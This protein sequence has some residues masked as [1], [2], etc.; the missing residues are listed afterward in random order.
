MDAFQVSPNKVIDSEQKLRT[1]IPAYSH[2]L[3]K[4]IRPALDHYCFEI[5]GHA[6]LLVFASSGAY[7]IDIF[8]QSQVK[9]LDDKTIQIQ[10]KRAAQNRGDIFAS[11]YF[12]IPGV[13]HGLRVNGRLCKHKDTL[14]LSVLG[15]YTHCARAAAR[16]ELWRDRSINPSDIKT[17]ETFIEASPYLLIKTMNSAFE[18]ELSPRG[19]HAGFVQLLN[20][21]TVFIPER[22]GNKV[23]ISLRNILKM[24]D[25]E[26]L[27]LVPGSSMTMRVLRSKFYA[28]TKTGLYHLKCHK[29][30]VYS[31][32]IPSF[33][34]MTRQCLR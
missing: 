23:A 21:N 3:D 18:T 19:D 27:M 4:R 11:L 26:L 16:S 9:I 32:I 14:V 2:I 17:P 20:P 31:F 1:I 34:E 33:S 22:P 5:I 30:Q 13:G 24:K 12:L 15:A 6:S 25:I 7:P 10:C 8:H 28:S 29:S